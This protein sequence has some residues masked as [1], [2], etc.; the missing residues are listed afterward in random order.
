MLLKTQCALFDDAQAAYE[1]LVPNTDVPLS[2]IAAAFEKSVMY[3][4]YHYENDKVLAHYCKGFYFDCVRYYCN[5]NSLPPAYVFARL[6]EVLLSK[7][8]DYANDDRLSNFK[9]S[10]LL[11]NLLPEQSCLALIATKIARAEQLLAS[12]K[13]AENESL[14][15]TILDLCGYAFLLYCIVTEQIK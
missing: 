14:N 4:F 8:N 3:A 13:T 12:G 2:E 10:A 7:G 6:N 9:R 15:D 1:N 11:I 5:T